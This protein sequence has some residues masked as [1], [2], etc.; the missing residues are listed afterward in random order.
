M[1]NIYYVKYI[2]INIKCNYFTIKMEKDDDDD[3]DINKGKAYS[4]CA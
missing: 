2:N 4:T 1:H 3:D